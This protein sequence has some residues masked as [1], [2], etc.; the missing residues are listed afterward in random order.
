MKEYL[1]LFRGGDGATVQQSPEKWQAHMQKWMQWMGGLTEKG[2]FLGAQPL[3]PEGKTVTGT[4]KVVS[5]GPFMEGKEMVGGYLICKATSFDEAVAISKGCPILE[6]D[7]GIVEVREIK[8]I[9]M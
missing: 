9:K 4:K 1:F 3:T 2:V 7:S 8:E 5:D 6:F